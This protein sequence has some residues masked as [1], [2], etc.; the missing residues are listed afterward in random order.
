[1]SEVHAKTLVVLAEDD[2]IIPLKSSKRLIAKFSDDLVQT[3]TIKGANH[4][5]VT[6]TD[7]YYELLSDFLADEE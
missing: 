2:R 5:D 4:N 6:D 7:L 1:M 3:V